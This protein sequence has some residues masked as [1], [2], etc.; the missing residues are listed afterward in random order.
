[1]SNLNNWH[2]EWMNELKQHE[3]RKEL[4]QIRLIKEAGANGSGWMVGAGKALG[5]LLA[6][7]KQDRHGHRPAKR[8]VHQS[9]HGKGAR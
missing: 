1:M 4:E 8:H 9:L 5:N 6:A 3:I 7:L 2:D